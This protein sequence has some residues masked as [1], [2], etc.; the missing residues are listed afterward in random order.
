MQIHRQKHIDLS[1][2][3]LPSAWAMPS[4]KASCR[5][6]VYC[7]TRK[8]NHSS[9]LTPT[10][11]CAESDTAPSK[12]A[13]FDRFTLMTSQPTVGDNEKSSIM[14][15]KKLTTG[16]PTRYRWS[17]YVTPMSLKGGSKSDFYNKIQLQL[18]KVFYKVS[19]CENFQ[20]QSCSMTIAPSN[21]P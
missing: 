8:G 11:I 5:P 17:S 13:D 15:N 19:V 20:R 16:F 14:T 10:E 3:T 12:H 4:A 7:T 9:F 18:N 21:G 6:V 1:Y 2:L